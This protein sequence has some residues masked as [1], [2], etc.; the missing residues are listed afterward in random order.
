MTG[1]KIGKQAVVIGA[2]MAGLDAA[3][4]VGRF[5]HVRRA[6]SAWPSRAAERRAWRRAADAMAMADFGPPLTEIIREI[7]TSC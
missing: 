5:E 6:L 1:G 2:G 4:A 3:G 7:S